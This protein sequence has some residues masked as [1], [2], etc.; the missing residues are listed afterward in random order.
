MTEDSDFYKGYVGTYIF[1]GNIMKIT[2]SESE[3]GKISILVVTN[4]TD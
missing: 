2:V 3:I 1:A 4:P